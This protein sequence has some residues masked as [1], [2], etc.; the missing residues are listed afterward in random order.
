METLK[1]YL[2]IYSS[3][4]STSITEA[5]SFRL[6]FVLL[7]VMD[8]FFYASTLFTVDFIYDHIELI[9]PWNREQLLFFLAYML[10]LDHLHM[11]ILSESFWVLSRDIRTGQLDYILLKPVDIIF[12]IFFR[13]FRP[14]SLCN[15][16]VVW[17]TLIYFGIKTQLSPLSWIML[18]LLIFI[19][20]LLLMILEFLIS[21]AMFWVTE[22]VSINFL[23]MQFQSL[24]RWPH[25][26]YKELY[27]KVFWV[28]LPLL[29]IGSAPVE[30]LLNNSAWDFLIYQV[31]ALI[32][33]Y[34]LM[35]ILWNIALKRYESASS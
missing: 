31:I 33:F 18:P 14:S 21:A 8:L 15:I 13:F 5:S 9:G 24:S 22:G 11:T 34:P 4:V 10:T 12:N 28:A 20:F 26:I 6:N 25:F 35:R 2:K 1:N 23:R 27:R 29:V 17:G 16:F 19:S 32:A 30:F 3:F 7:I